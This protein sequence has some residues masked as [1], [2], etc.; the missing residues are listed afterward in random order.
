[1]Q[2]ITEIIR[3]RRFA[4]RK[5]NREKRYLI[6]AVER[7]HSRLY[8]PFDFVPERILFDLTKQI[9]LSPDP[10]EFCNEPHGDSYGRIRL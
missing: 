9:D 6:L 3:N 5:I 10:S 7:V 2:T 8:V 1:M 4:I